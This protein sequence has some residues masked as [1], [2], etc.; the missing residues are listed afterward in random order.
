MANAR[1]R[2]IH[3]FLAVSGVGKIQA[4]YDNFMLHADLDTRDAC[5]IEMNDDVERRQ[6][7][8]CDGVDLIREPIRRRFTQFRLTYDKINGQIAARWT[9]YHQGVSAASTG[10][11]ANEVVTITRN[12]T[13]SGGTFTISITHEGKTGT[14]DAIAWDASNADILAALL[15]KTGS[16]TA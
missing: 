8:D 10:A 11:A 12:G 6:E 5:T 7:Y 16:A 9:A 13:V 14:T 2:Q 1:W 4:A 3:Q 15:K